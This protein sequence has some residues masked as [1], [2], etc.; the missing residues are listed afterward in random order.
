MSE[1]TQ[2]NLAPTS[3]LDI[4][5]RKRLD[6]MNASY[7]AGELD[8]KQIVLRARFDIVNIG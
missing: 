1:T 2:N 3:P 6:E 8:R 5:Q 4:Q 7:F